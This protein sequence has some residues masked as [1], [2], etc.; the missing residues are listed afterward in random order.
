MRK[1]REILRLKWECQYSY[2]LIAKSCGVSSSTACECVRRATRAN[3]TWPLPADL[4]DE[5]LI[6][7]LY[8]QNKTTKKDEFT[9]IDFAKL[10]QE[11]KKKHVTKM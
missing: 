10:H 5:A 8:K 6:A 3:L 4:D 1:I 11:L 7:L 2:H 9:K